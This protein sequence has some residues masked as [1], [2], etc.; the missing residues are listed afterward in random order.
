MWRY[1]AAVA[2][3]LLVSGCTSEPDPARPALWE[4]TTPG[5]Q[6]GW[7]FGTIHALKR[8]ADWRSAKV[9]KALVLA[10]TLV[11]ELVDEGDEE[12]DPA[13]I[14]AQ[15]AQ[16]KRIPQLDERVEPA[17]RGRLAQVLKQAGLDEN[18]FTD[19]ET[20][21]V[22]L[23]LARASD[24]QANS[25]HGIDR[26]LRAH[27]YEHEHGSRHELEGVRGQLSI[28]DTLPEK[29][30]RDLLSAVLRDGGK[31]DQQL[32]SAWRRGDM[33]TIERETTHGMLA[34]PEL[35]K[36]LLTDRN[37]NWAGQI[38]ALLRRGQAPFVAVGAAHMAGPDGLPAL[39]GAKGYTVTRIQ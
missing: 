3:L 13:R 12:R 26:A 37:R 25:K 32:A 31:E 18:Q 1:L 17:L 14:F 33:A 29:E 21:A 15:L 27:W 19:T 2:A 9:E 4:I 39:L 24:S 8:P 28:F 35:R 6:K 16:N 20:W 38:E 23:T 30:Q 5:G 11:V 10:D 34:D 36:A 7:L 22:A